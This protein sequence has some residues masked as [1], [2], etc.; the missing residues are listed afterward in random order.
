MLV[1]LG[2]RQKRFVEIWYASDS[3]EIRD[4]FRNGNG[5]R[6]DYDSCDPFRN[7][8]LFREFT[9][10]HFAKRD[11]VNRIRRGLDELFARFFGERDNFVFRF[12]RNFRMPK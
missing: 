1:R 2:R 8:M 12:V 11:V 6:I 10:K 7:V 3:A 4:L 9:Q 5:H